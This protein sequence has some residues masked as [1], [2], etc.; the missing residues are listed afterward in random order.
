MAKWALVFSVAGLFFMAAPAAWAA[1][2]RERGGQAAAGGG[3]PSGNTAR[4]SASSV[5]ANE[6]G[7]AQRP[8]VDLFDAEVVPSYATGFSVAYHG[9][10]KVVRV[11]RPWPG[12]KGGFEYLLVERGAQA[13]AGYP[14]AVRVTIPVHSVVALSATY[15]AEIGMLGEMATLKGIQRS[16]YVYS[17]EVRLGVQRGRIAQVGEGAATNV[18]LLIALRPDVVFAVGSGGAG[19]IY[20]KLLEAGLPVVLDGD[21]AEPTPLGRAE[22]I[23]F[24][25]LFYNKER[26]AN[27]LFA[28]IAAEYNRLKA[29]AAKAP[30][31][32]TVFVNAPW[33]GSWGMPGGK[34]YVAALLRDA[35]ADY[36]WANTGASGTQ[37]L[38]LEAVIDRA[39]NAD[40]WLNT[41]DYRTRADALAAD[42]RFAQFKAFKDDDLYNNNARVTPEGGNDYWESGPVRPQVVLADLIKIF[43]PGLLPGHELT[44]YRRVR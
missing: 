6:A 33:Q 17:R 40:F 42:P 20:P 19:E 13:P 15:L 1:G 27:A 12:A 5:A 16:S 43:H 30:D 10:Y 3:P 38:S 34:S 37:P 25:A 44:Y 9:T 31:R 4:P 22:W 41:G 32:P 18:E 2:I 11:T 24:I 28:A 39:A 29:L 14:N 21:W 7:D 35:G 36:L 8:P 23:K 26:E